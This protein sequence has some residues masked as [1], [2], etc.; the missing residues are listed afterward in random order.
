M[1]ALTQDLLNEL[2][3]YDKETGNLFWK[4]NLNNQMKSG[5]IAG[6]TAVSGYRVV[7]IN[8]R[9]YLVHRII[10]IMVYGYIPV[11]IDHINHQK[12][13]NRLINIREA[14][15]TENQRNC[16]LKPTNTSGFNG[17]AYLSKKGG[18]KKWRA[19]VKVDNKSIHIGYY[20]TK[21]EAIAARVR[22]NKEYG[23]HENHGAIA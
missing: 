23:F 13:D 2:F 16:K 5:D 21:D 17:V 8:R 15:N 22:A 7:I 11:G 14:N 18:E 12:S 4:N 1:D 9:D 19:S 20:L 10:W 6:T 3:S